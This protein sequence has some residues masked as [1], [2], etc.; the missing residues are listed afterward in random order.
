MPLRIEATGATLGAVVTGVDLAL[1]DDPSWRAIEAAFHEHALLVFPGQHLASPLQVAFARRFGDI[2]HLY[3]DSGVVP[4]SNQRRDGSL[5][6]DHEPAM[7]VMRGNE[8]WHTDSSYM[9]ISARASVLSA[10][11]VPAAGGETEWADMRAA[12]DALDAGTRERIAGL[13]AFHSL[14]VSQARIGHTDPGYRGIRLPGR[15]SA[16]ASAGEDPSGDRPGGALHRPPR[17]RNPRP[18]PHRVGEVARRASRARVSAAA[19]PP[20]RVAARGPRHLG[21]PLRAAPGEAV[22]SPPGA[23]H[24]A[25]AHRR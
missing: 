21:Q 3:G 12:Y 22:R 5:L 18:R 9:P 4:I 20:P 16:A 25:H 11:V 1:L 2:E 8:G 6:E 14:R 7:Q 10:H 19:G 17:L 15:R 24:E 13:E 23:H